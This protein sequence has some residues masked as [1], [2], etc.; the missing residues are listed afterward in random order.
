MVDALVL[1]LVAPLEVHR[2]HLLVRADA[3]YLGSH[4]FDFVEVVIWIALVCRTGCFDYCWI[5]L[6]SC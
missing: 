6:T 3:E 1:P 5:F 4:I 2:C